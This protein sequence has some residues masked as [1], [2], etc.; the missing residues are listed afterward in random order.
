MGRYH[1]VCMLRSW[2]PEREPSSRECPSRP[3][4]HPRHE[5]CFAHH[6]SLLQKSLQVRVQHSKWTFSWVIKVA[7]GK[8]GA[9]SFQPLSDSQDVL[10]RLRCALSVHCVCRVHG[11]IPE[12]L[13][14]RCFHLQA[15]P[16]DVLAE[17][18]YVPLDY[19]SSSLELLK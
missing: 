18:R 9:L 14:T 19:T 3:D 7:G 15:L 2:S 5:L 16:D 10:F 4:S 12:T 17:M 6:A 1:R 8:T 11:T 13:E